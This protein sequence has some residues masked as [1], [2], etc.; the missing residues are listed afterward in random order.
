MAVIEPTSVKSD[1]V[2]YNFSLKDEVP[3]MSYEQYLEVEDLVDIRETPT[4][5]IAD[6]GCTRSMGS[7]FAIERMQEVMEPLGVTFE[8]RRCYTKMTFAN[9]ED[10]ILDWCVLVAFPTVPPIATTIDAF[11]KGSLPVLLSLPQM[12]ICSVLSS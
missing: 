1:V 2:Q 9:S 4:Y 12:R 6:L 10:A 11:T 3:T 7:V 8:W 5:A